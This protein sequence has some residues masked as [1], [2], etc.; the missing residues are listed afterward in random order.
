MNKIK[1]VNFNKA[2]AII[3]PYSQ[4]IIAGDFVFCSGQIG[5]DPKTGE[6][7]QGIEKQ[8]EQVLKNLE[9]ILKEI[10][11]SLE[12]VV[13]TTVYLKNISEFSK[14]NK[15]YANFFKKQKPARATVEVSNLPKNALIEIEAIA[16]V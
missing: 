6:L 14:M 8:T 4:A 9:V 11:L 10:D 16:V 15:I 5:I 12:N 3:G 2:P 7:K 13:K 1:I